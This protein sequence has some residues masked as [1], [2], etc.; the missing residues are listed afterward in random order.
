[1]VTKADW[2]IIGVPYTPMGR[3]KNE[4]W[5]MGG[6]DGLNVFS[7][8]WLVR[9]V[10]DDVVGLGDSSLEVKMVHMRLSFE[11]DILSGGPEYAPK[12]LKYLYTPR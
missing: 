10:D 11:V 2:A 4:I 8:S 7:T 3:Y 1:M 5:N 6:I 12:R 9:R